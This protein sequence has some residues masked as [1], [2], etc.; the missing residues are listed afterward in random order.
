MCPLLEDFFFFFSLSLPALLPA[1]ESAIIVPLRSF[2]FFF[3]LGD[4][5][6]ERLRDARASNFLLSRRGKGVRK[7][8]GFNP[9]FYDGA[10]FTPRRAICYG[11]T[12]IRGIIFRGLRDLD[13]P[14]RFIVP[15]SQPVLFIFIST[16][17]L[18]RGVLL[19][20]SCGS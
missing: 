12:P 15:V 11:L 2:L 7:R 1:R 19:K 4:C 5:V 17:Q 20:E 10:L 3:S 8:G 16:T 6:R 14:L 13:D 18:L 9:F